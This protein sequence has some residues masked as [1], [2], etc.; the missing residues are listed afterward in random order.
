MRE[1]AI[2]PILVALAFAAPFA[3]QAQPAATDEEIAGAPP[4]PPLDETH[5]EKLDRLFADLAVA[6]GTA[7]EGVADEIRREMSKSGSDSMD[8]LLERARKAMH[9][10]N[11]ERARMHLSA[12]TRLAPDFAEGWNAAATLAYIQED[13][14]RAVY[15]IERALAIEPRHFSALAG[16][17][18]IFERLERK[19]AAMRAWREAARLYPS[20]EPAEEAIR[21]LS[22]EVDGRAL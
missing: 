3:A 9:E 16:L 21:R 13:Y 10:K 18:M 2:G 14:G 1:L 7:A 22:P 17:A 15:E 8:F 20:L 12:L 5:A 4:P 6:D 11:Y 19:D